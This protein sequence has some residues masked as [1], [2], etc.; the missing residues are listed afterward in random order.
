MA[1]QQNDA[2]IR[3]PLNY[4]TSLIYMDES[5]TA[6]NG[7]VFVLGALKV[8]RHGRL[9]RG[10]HA[11]R[12]STGAQGEL[13]FN[14]VNRG[15]VRNFT[16][17]LDVLPVGDVFFAATIVDRQ[18]DDPTKGRPRW[19]AHAEIASHLLRGCINRRELVSV[20]MDTISTPPDVAFEDEIVNR[21]NRRFRSKAIIT[22]A[23]LDSRT[24]DGLQLVDILTSAVAW[25]YR[26]RVGMQ[27][28][29]SQYKGKVV[30][31]AKQ[32]LG[33]TEL[34]G[35]SERSKVAVFR[36]RPPTKGSGVDKVVV[37][38]RRQAG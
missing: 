25:D 24:C 20:A 31:H 28:K 36:T 17:M 26:Q 4:P 29:A 11:A 30:E 37:L 16:A 3:V 2:P 19:E 18:I 8:R 23:M 6:G 14:R 34:E 27:T 38:S 21:V 35:R 10:L 33:V 15:N 1:K 22:A 12:D 9:A 7:R 13:R 32:V 5:G